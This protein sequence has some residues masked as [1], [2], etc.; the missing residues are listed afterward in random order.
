M[1]QEFVENQGDGWQ[2]ALDELGRF[3][4]QCDAKEKAEADVSF[5]VP[6][7]SEPWRGEIPPGIR[8]RLGVF[9]DTAANLGKRTAEMHLALGSQADDPA[10]APE[11]FT[12][13]DLLEL[14]T[15]LRE[16]ASAVFD[17]LK[18]SLAR[19]PDDVTE[20]ASFLL[21]RRR[22]VLAALNSLVSLDLQCEK[23]RVH[24]HYHLG[25]VLLVAGD[26]VI[27]DFEGEPAHPLAVSAAKQLAVKDVA[28]MLRSF[29]YAAQ[30]AML[31]YAARGTESVE[32]VEP[33]ARFWERATSAAFLRA[34]CASA[35]GAAFLPA[36]STSFR[37]LLD[38]FLLDKALYELSEELENRPAW[39]SIPL[40][41]ILSLELMGDAAA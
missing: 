35:G 9:Y 10:F 23:I 39:V 36:T 25:Q 28:G 29:S 17:L 15:A 40:T 26:H 6:V 32:R 1:A 13:S 33:W 11:T 7:L 20:K 22:P 21:S 2:V 8:E 5:D 14:I 4:E 19:L 38:A 3:F 27:L 16:H 12:R 31:S 34:Y 18:K 30:T 41:G 37:R 24:G